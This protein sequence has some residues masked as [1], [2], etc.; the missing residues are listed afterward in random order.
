MQKSKNKNKTFAIKFFEKMTI[1][2][3]NRNDNKKIA[4]VAFKTIFKSV[5]TRV[6]FVKKNVYDFRNNNNNNVVKELFR[7]R[8]NFFIIFMLAN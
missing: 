2:N 1:T 5:I 8:N 6:K 4:F 3:E 7:N